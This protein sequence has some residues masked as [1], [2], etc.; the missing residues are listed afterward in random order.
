MFLPALIINPLHKHRYTFK[1]TKMNWK[2]NFYFALVL[3]IFSNV[4]YAQ[5]DSD[6]VRFENPPSVVTP[7]GYTQ[8]VII[9]FGKFK[10]VTMS[11]QVPFDSLGSLVGKGDFYMQAEQVFRNIKKIVEQAGG[12]MSHLIKLGFFVTDMTQLPALREVRDKFI[13]KSKPPTSTLVQ[14]SRLF[15]D[16]VFLEVEASAIIPK[17]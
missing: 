2:Y 14:V 13:N 16:D 12:N 1:H 3:T 15:R 9:D 5:V 7:K 6:L 11:G 4:S 17:D 10:M 8:A